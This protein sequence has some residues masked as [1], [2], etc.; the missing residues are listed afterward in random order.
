MEPPLPHHAIFSLAQG[1]STSNATSMEME[2]SST[3]LHVSVPFPRYVCVISWIYRV[4]VNMTLIVGKGIRV[5][6]RAFNG[7]DSVSFH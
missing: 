1:A 6:Y 2:I 3:E 7:I 5:I 4:H